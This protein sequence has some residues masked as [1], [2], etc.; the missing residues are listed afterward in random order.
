MGLHV[1][2][3]EVLGW[4]LSGSLGGNFTDGPDQAPPFPAC[5]KGS[6][7]VALK[8]CSPCGRIRSQRKK[9]E[10]DGG[11][12]SVELCTPGFKSQLGHLPTV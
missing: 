10:M 11:I 2:G 3:K 5:S 4:P 1:I 12:E 9:R 7:T 8:E 6:A